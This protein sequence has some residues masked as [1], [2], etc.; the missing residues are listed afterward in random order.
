MCSQVSLQDTEQ[1]GAG[2]GG[3]GGKRG[4]VLPC[5]GPTLPLEH[6]P[7]GA[8]ELLRLVLEHALD[9]GICGSLG[10][11]FHVLLQTP[12]VLECSSSGEGFFSRIPSPF[13]DRVPGNTPFHSPGANQAG[14]AS[15]LTPSVGW[16]RAR[17][18]VCRAPAEEM[19]VPCRDD[20]PCLRRG[21][22]LAVVL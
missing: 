18:Q 6:T 16:R 12:A 3:A 7:A 19:Q 21:P 2:V 4:Y 1:S 15:V 5:C 22:A 13:Q 9:G 20:T 17:G 8:Q 14:K 11:A 10:P